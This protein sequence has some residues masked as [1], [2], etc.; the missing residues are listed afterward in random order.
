[1][2]K[3]TVTVIVILII[4][5]LTGFLILKNDR[6]E[7]TKSNK[8]ICQI[9]SFT[10]T[11]NGTEIEIS[12]DSKLTVEKVKINLY[13]SNNKKVKTIEKSIGKKT[14]NNEIIK[15]DEKNQYPEVANIKCAVYETRS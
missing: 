5:I 3:I 6:K 14:N 4:V 9:E 7:I 2:K 11:D 8:D 15:I 12:I 1:M 13:D 10:L